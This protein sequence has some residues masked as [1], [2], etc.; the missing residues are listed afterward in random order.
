MLVSSQGRSRLPSDGRWLASRSSERAA[1]SAFAAL[2]CWPLRR[3]VSARFH[4][5]RLEPPGSRTLNQQVKSFWH[6]VRPNPVYC[7]S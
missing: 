5:R 3:I 4:K 1:R 6:V 7:F 2:R